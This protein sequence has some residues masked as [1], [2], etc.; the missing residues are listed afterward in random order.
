MTII[1]ADGYVV[2]TQR[3][4]LPLTTVTVIAAPKV[5]NNTASPLLVESILLVNTAAG[6]PTVTV[7][8]WDGTNSR[9]LAVI[10]LAAAG[11]ADSRW[12]MDFSQVVPA[13]S[14]I[15]ASATT[16]NV[17]AHVTRGAKGR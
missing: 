3:T 8:F 13:G 5:V 11:A 1:R 14:T 12:Q 2:E 10:T 4:A 9:V 15:R 17:H 16:A 7:D 6:T